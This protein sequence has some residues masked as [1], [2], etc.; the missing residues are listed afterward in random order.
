M[1]MKVIGPR[2]VAS[3]AI[4]GN[5]LMIPA[6][7]GV[8]NLLTVQQ[9]ITGNRRDTYGVENMDVTLTQLVQIVRR[10]DVPFYNKVKISN[11]L[12]LSCA[13]TTM[14]MGE[15][16]F[17]MIKDIIPEKTKIFGYSFKENGEI[18]RNL[19]VVGSIE[20]I[21]FSLSEMFTPITTLGTYCLPHY[22]ENTKTI[23]MIPVH[24]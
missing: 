23:S 9:M 8:D 20:A 18:T 7:S 24:C 5:T 22:N 21:N 14:F 1:E 17:V 15:D 16:D 11:G 10:S 19:Y 2:L 4:T 3:S 6:D 12:E 13:P